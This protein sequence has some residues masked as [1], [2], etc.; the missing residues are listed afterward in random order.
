MVFLVKKMRWYLNGRCPWFESPRQGLCAMAFSTHE[1][2]PQEIALPVLRAHF[3][4]ARAAELDLNKCLSN[5]LE[6]MI[7]SLT[8]DK[9]EE[10]LRLFQHHSYETNHVGRGTDR[11]IYPDVSFPQITACAVMTRAPSSHGTY[12]YHIDAGSHSAVPWWAVLTRRLVYGGFLGLTIKSHT[13]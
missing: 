3:S 2:A 9:M 5:I 1:H 10:F 8:L 13:F 7:D 11:G 4:A 6:E 12:Q